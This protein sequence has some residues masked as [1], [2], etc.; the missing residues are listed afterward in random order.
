[1]LCSVLVKI[2]VA[3]HSIHCLDFHMGFQNLMEFP[4]GLPS[5]DVTY[6]NV[7]DNNIAYLDA[8]I[9][10][11]CSVL[12]TFNIVKNSLVYIHPLTFAG[13]PLRNL[14][15]GLN[16]MTEIPDLTVVNNTL[17][18]ISAYSNEIS[19]IGNIANLRNLRQLYLGSN[20]VSVLDI[21]ILQSLPDL[22]VAVLSA[23]MISSITG[24][25]PNP[26]PIFTLKLEQNPLLECSC[27][28][29]R[30]LL[31][32]KSVLDVVGN[33]TVPVNVLIEMCA[34]ECLG[35]VICNVLA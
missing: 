20:K 13:T 15:F 29:M 19:D 18:F 10:I 6:I 5:T 33:C 26:L 30:I 7:T 35:K 11:N 25:E 21:S 32:M 17:K 23:N 12:D 9:L 3:F 34:G 24:F 1:M 16:L 2:V 31:A 28:T 8:N 22:K 27:D 14:H 4:V